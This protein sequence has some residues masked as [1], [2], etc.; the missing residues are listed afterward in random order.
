MWW[1][2]TIEWQGP[3]DEWSCGGWLLSRQLSQ[4][5][6]IAVHCE[7]WP[8][9]PWVKHAWKNG[10]SAQIENEDDVG[11]A[12]EQRGSAEASG[13]QRACVKDIPRVVFVWQSGPQ[14][15]SPRHSSRRL[16]RSP[17]ALCMSLPNFYSNS[18]SLVTHG[19]F[20]FDLV[21]VCTLLINYCCWNLSV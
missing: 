6:W 5:L 14:Y 3:L 15:Q 12:G 4:V 13:R 21:A 17:L 20:R 10:Y 9:V 7:A 11:G 1:Y 18:I 16:V 2:C 8:S 19:C